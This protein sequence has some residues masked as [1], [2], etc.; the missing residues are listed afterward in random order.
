MFVTFSLASHRFFGDAIKQSAAWIAFF[1][2]RI[3]AIG[4]LMLVEHLHA[5]VVFAILTVGL[6]AYRIAHVGTCHQVAFVATVNEHLGCD[7]QA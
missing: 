7:F 1:A 3:D 2:I 5:V 6:T 4:E